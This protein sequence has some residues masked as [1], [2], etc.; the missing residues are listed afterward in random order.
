M[1]RGCFTYNWVTN[2]LTSWLVFSNMFL[3]SISYI[4]DVILPIDELIFFKM[5]IA[6]PTRSIFW[7]Y[8]ILTH[9]HIVAFWDVHLR[10]LIDVFLGENTPG[11][12]TFG[13]D[14]ITV[15]IINH[16]LKKQKQDIQII[17]NQNMI[18]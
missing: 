2:Q 9:A 15:Y 1:V 6:P 12:P 10:S 8:P 3:F 5:V 16:T 13:L 18:W 17:I 4:C 7:G 14:L 11:N